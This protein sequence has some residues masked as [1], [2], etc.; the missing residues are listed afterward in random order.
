MK[1]VPYLEGFRIV[2]GTNGRN[3]CITLRKMGLSSQ[4]GG[5]VKFRGRRE[6]TWKRDCKTLFEVWARA[7]RRE[8]E[9][10]MP[11]FEKMLQGVLKFEPGGEIGA[12]EVV[13]LLLSAWRL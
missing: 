5:S 4:S 2:G 10:V 1:I 13:R 11:A 7:R 12:V 6:G 8:L 3:D 9:L